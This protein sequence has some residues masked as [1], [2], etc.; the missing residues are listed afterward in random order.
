MAEEQGSIGDGQAQVDGQEGLGDLN[1]ESAKTIQGSAAP[2]GKAF[3]TGLTAQ[4]LDAVRAAFAV[5]DQSMKRRVGVAKVVA[6]W[7][8][9]RVSRGA[10]GFALAARTLAFTPRQHIGFTNMTSEGRGMRASTHGAI[11]GSARLEGTR[12]FAFG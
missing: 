1:G 7:I 4:P 11:V 6:V 10:D 8:R 5:P 9:A 3:A 12:R 2:A